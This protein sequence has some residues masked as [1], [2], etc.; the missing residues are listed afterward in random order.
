MV[1]HGH[2]DLMQIVLALHAGRRFADFLHRR[3]E[4]GDQDADDGDHYQQL[5]QGKGT[6]TGW[7]NRPHGRD[8]LEGI[9]GRK[10]KGSA[11]IIKRLFLA[12]VAI[13]VYRNAKPVAPGSDN[14]PALRR[15]DR[16]TYLYRDGDVV[17]TGWSNARISWPR[18]RRLDTR[19][20]GSG[21]LVDEELARAIRIES[22][23]AIQH[24]WGVGM[25]AV[26]AWRKALGVGRFNEGSAKLRKRVNARTAK[27]LKGRRLPPEQVERRRQTAK[28]LGLRPKQSYTGGRPWTAEELALLGTVPDGELA[29][30]IGRTETAVRVRRA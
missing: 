16:A 18:C 9:V 17:I 2:A 20:G 1:E 11:I 22:S 10:V 12:G 6:V 8:L 4:Q 29:A 27:K 14:L 30:Q 15:G 21:L 7:Y 19:R 5:D 13:W 3:Q 26:W 25:T 23:L 28:A 24:W